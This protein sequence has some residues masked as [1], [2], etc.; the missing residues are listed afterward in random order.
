VANIILSVSDISISFGGLKAVNNV[1]LEVHQGSLT[2][3]IGPNGAGKTTLFA[4]I[5]GF[6]KPNQGS[7]RYCGQDITGQ[8]PHINAVAGMTRTFQIVQPFAAQTVLEN[9]AV[10]AHLHYP[11]R[12]AAL[13]FAHHIALRVGLDGQINKPA[14]DLTVAGR[15]RL[16]LARALA[17]KPKLLLL[18]EVLAGLN[19]QEIA[20]MI[21]VIRGIAQQGVTVL[22]IEHVMQA[23]MNLAEHI[24]VLAQGELIAQGK[25]NEITQNK[26]VIEAYLGAGAADRLNQTDRAL[27]DNAR[28]IDKGCPTHVADAACATNYKVTSEATPKVSVTTPSSNETQYNESLLVVTG[29][30]GGY[31]RTEVLRGI[32]LTVNRGETVALLGSNGAGKTT[33]NQMICG[34]VPTQSGLVKFNDIDITGAHY[35]HIVT[36]GLI[37]VPEGR[38]IFPNL[39]VLENLEL[40][41]FSRARERRQENIE[42]VFNTFP[43]LRERT[44]QLAGTMSGGEQQMLAIGRG[45][46]AEPILLILDEPS[47]GLS[48]RLVEEMFELIQKLRQTGLSILLVEQNVAQ[49]LDIADRVYVMENGALKFSGLPSGLLGSDE[50]RRSYLGL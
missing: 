11:I 13:E 19:P 12:H 24:W 41:S 17:A 16:E 47:L 49:S 15:K 50:L 22:M 37:Q 2:A 20:E 48:P 25:P 14:S 26:K 30:R 43:R 8:A 5:S 40:G 6:L 45:L 35:T 4:L 32:D 42:Y 28:Q 10:G 31:G 21:P 3:L 36:R 44:K 18:D 7:V 33:F 38:K 27:K 39:T 34:L 1:S 23:V 9:I 46:M 29:L